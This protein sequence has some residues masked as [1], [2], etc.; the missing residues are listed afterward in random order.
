MKDEAVVRE[1]MLT[2]L[3]MTPE[4]EPEFGFR[5]KR[6]TTELKRMKR[7]NYEKIAEVIKSYVRQKS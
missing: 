4:V 6:K 7:R 1:D 3:P 2:S 5:S